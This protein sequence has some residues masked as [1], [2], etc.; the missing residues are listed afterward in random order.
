MI[1]DHTRWQTTD[2]QVLRKIDTFWKEK[3]VTVVTKV[4]KRGQ[5]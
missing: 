3:L 4:F 2:S 1:L 5:Y